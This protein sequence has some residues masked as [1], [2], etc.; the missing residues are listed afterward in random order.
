MA[1]AEAFRRIGS[2]VDEDVAVVEGGE[3]LDRARPQHAVAEDVA[4]HVAD[5]DDGERRALDVGP[6]LAEM[7][8]HRFPGAAGGD[9]HL[10]VVVAG[11]AAGREGVVEPEAVLGRDGV[12][13]VGEGRRALVGGDDKIGIVVVMAHDVVGRD[14]FLVGEIVGDV[15]QG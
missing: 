6:E 8:L 13:K 7:P 12:G 11:R 9:A 10:L 2:G 1:L 3:E 5:A 14:H 15:E 4:R